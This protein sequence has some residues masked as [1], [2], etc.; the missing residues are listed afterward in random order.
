MRAASRRDERDEDFPDDEDEDEEG[1]L[2]SSNDDP[3]SG[4]DRLVADLKKINEQKLEAEIELQAYHR[5]VYGSNDPPRPSPKKKKSRFPKI[6]SSGSSP[7]SPG[8]GSAYA[9]L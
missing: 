9:V 5:Q 8:S 4:Y 6:R 7:S 3:T 2:P 1:M